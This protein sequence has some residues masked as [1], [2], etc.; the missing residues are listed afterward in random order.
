M[1]ATL[2]SHLVGDIDHTTSPSMLVLLAFAST[3][4]GGYTV[5]HFYGLWQSWRDI[6]N[7]S[8]GPVDD[9]GI[10]FW[11]GPKG[12][13]L[14]VVTLPRFT[15]KLEDYERVEWGKYLEEHRQK[16]LLRAD[17]QG[18]CLA[19]ASIATSGGLSHH[20]FED[21]KRSAAAGCLLCGLFITT[22]TANNES[23]GNVQIEKDRLYLKMAGEIAFDIIKL[24]DCQSQGKSKIAIQA[25][26]N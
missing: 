12:S 25:S 24:R 11:W 2:W 19:C 1:L 3:L 7:F 22:S 26:I 8:T 21:M 20:R 13:G 9:T 16:L 17:S 4:L 6:L 10:R 18:F 14:D 5:V 23:N 15:S